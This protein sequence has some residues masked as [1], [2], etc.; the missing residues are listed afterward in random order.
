MAIARHWERAA[1]SKEEVGI[2]GGVTEPMNRE[3]NDDL[4]LEAAFDHGELAGVGV[5]GRPPCSFPADRRPRPRRRPSS[6]LA[7]IK[8]MGTVGRAR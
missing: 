3:L 1:V 6:P 8:K 4:E 5:A 7:V 2:D